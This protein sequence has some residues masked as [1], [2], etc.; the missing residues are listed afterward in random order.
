MGGAIAPR[1]ADNTAQGEGD[2]VTPLRENE[3]K[4]AL[5]P[6]YSHDS[7]L[8]WITSAHRQVRTRIYFMSE[9]HV[10]ALRNVLRFG[11]TDRGFAGC[12]C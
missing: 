7:L 1:A 3:S 11:E 4:L 2:Q 6:S 8:Q 12:R 5:D 10:H 9:S